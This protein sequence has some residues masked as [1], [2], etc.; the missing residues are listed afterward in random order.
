MPDHD[1]RTLLETAD[2]EF[3]TVMQCVF[4]VQAHEIRTYLTLLGHPGSTADELAAV[5]DRDRSNVN[6]SLTTLLETGLVERE[7]RLL[8][9]GG[10]VYQYT[11]VALPE[12]KSMVKAGLDA[13]TE[14]VH[15]VV[16]AYEPPASAATGGGP[17][18]G[19]SADDA[20]A[21]DARKDT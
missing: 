5:L 20:S 7:R 21:G 6:R 9:G 17:P 16:E 11:G 18:S 8:E 10:Y 13:W 3:E 1:M 4:G 19:S 14:T 12:A 2:P 15:E